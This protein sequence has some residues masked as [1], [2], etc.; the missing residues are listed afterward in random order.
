MASSTRKPAQF[1]DY[2][3]A[4]R[5]LADGLS[6]LPAL[7]LARELQAK[8][9]SADNAALLR[10]VYLRYAES[11]RAAQKTAALMGLLNEAEKL[12]LP[13]GDTG[14]QW[15]A[16][17]IEYR[18]ATGEIRRVLA[19]AQT[20]TDA[21]LRARVMGGVGDRIVRTA[22]K[23]KLLPAEYLPAYEAFVKAFTHYSAGQYE[24]ARNLLT[25]IPSSSIFIEMKLMLRGLIAWN[26]GDDAT[27]LEN[28][29]RLTPTRMAAEMIAPVRAQIDPAWTKAQ[30]LVRRAV[31]SQR[32]INLMPA[33]GTRVVAELRRLMARTSEGLTPVLTFLRK[34]APEL[35][36]ASPKVFAR[37]SNLMYWAML[38]R[39]SPDDLSEYKK[40]FP[41]HADDPSFFR[42]IAM[43]QEQVDAPENA[44]KCWNE[45]QQWVEKNA[46]RWPGSQA[47]LARSIIF[48]RM[49]GLVE[50]TYE[51]DDEDDFD[52]DDEDDDEEQEFTPNPKP[53]PKGKAKASKGRKPAKA[54]AKPA[55]LAFDEKECYRLAR[56]A[57]PEWSVPTVKLL[58][59]LRQ[60]HDYE[61]A[62]ELLL[63]LSPTLMNDPDVVKIAGE[64]WFKLGQLARSLEARRA[65]LRINP[66]DKKVRRDFAL[67]AMTILR[68]KFLEN[69][70]P[71]IL[72]LIKEINT[73]GDA[74]LKLSVKVL[75]VCFHFTR[76][77]DDEAA[78]ILKVLEGD[79][80][81]KRALDYR[82]AV[83]S[84]RLKLSP[85]RKKQ[86][87]TGFDA[88]LGGK[89][90]IPEMIHL[91]GAL[92][93][94]RAE[95]TAYRGLI[96]H[97]R[98]ILTAL[99]T[100]VKLEKTLT[101]LVPLG[102]ML[103]QFGYWKQLE[104]LAHVG[105]RLS[106]QDLWM[107]FFEIQA[108][109]LSGKNTRMVYRYAPVV[110]R[111]LKE[112]EKNPSPENQAVKK[113]LEELIKSN[114]DLDRTINNPFHFW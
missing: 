65:A 28:W 60:K 47:A 87:A 85:T 2:P 23:D 9:P 19:M 50:A 30:H 49:G 110:M 81:S 6:F 92:S 27:A 94:Y 96:T 12:P 39:G 79:P 113:E 11:L 82:L 114:P 31:L 108:W 41:P 89:P 56:E 75:E 21:G 109:S 61:K 70:E 72:S 102:R 112:L 7:E 62:S 37:L 42:L 103:A 29:K 17:V 53:K 84:S 111:M 15:L 101:V 25:P 105:R 100:A 55:E 1:D 46:A 80:V 22:N 66:L 59:S 14:Q 68:G 36:T 73:H 13:E 99:E 88:A 18:I 78:A 5:E 40:I 32:G 71:A 97:E 57:S 107:R 38:E 45:Y 33:A 51:D 104:T 20:L 3:T 95:P 83:E 67:C 58:E 90:T 54:A 24:V 8:L 76:R 77:R 52:E 4:V 48:T 93:E 91:L 35:K 69:D 64:V 106:A 74:T 86:F 26:G 34:T 43:I 44:Y 98:K 16:S 63:T 10:S